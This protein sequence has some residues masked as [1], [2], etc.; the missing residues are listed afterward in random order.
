M[1]PKV[2]NLNTLVWSAE[3]MLSRLIS[4]NVEMVTVTA[5]NLA[6]SEPIPDRSNR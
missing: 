1:Q 6:P 2:F 3:K 5:K 4:E